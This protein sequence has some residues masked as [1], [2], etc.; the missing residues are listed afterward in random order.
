MQGK[1]L[2]IPGYKSFFKNRIDNS[3]GGLI[4]AVDQNLSSV[5]V[6]SCEEDI[7]VVEIDL[8]NRKIRVINIYGPQEPQTASERQKVLEFWQE[9]EKQVIKSKDDNCLTIL[10]G[11]A[12][13]KLGHLIFPKDPHNQTENGSIMYDFVQRNNLYILNTDNNC[14]GSI[15]RHKITRVKEEKS[16]IDYFVICEGLKQYFEKMFIDDAR[17]YTLTKYSTTKGVKTKTLSDHN[18]LFASFGL[19]YSAVRMKTKYEI[20]DFKNTEGQKKF[21]EVTNTSNKLSKC[22]ESNDDFLHQTDNFLKKLNGTFHQCFAKIRIKNKTIIERKDDIQMSLQKKTDL[23]HLKSQMNSNFTKEFFETKIE[24]IDE[25]ISTKSADRNAHIIREQLDTLIDTEGKFSNVGMWKIKSKLF[26]QVADPPI[27]KKDSEGNL[28]TGVEPLKHL[29]SDT[30]KQRLRHRPMRDDLQDLFS[31]KNLLWELRSQQCRVNVSEAWNMKDLETV[32]KSL[33]NNQSRDPLGMVN[34]IFKPGVVGKDLKTAILALMNG[35]KKNFQIPTFMQ[36]S[37]IT[38]IYKMKGSRLEMENERG[39]FILTVFR[40]IYDKLLYNDKYEYIDSNMSDS[41]I[42]GRK[43]RNIKNHLFIVYGVINAAIGEKTCIDICI[44]DLEKA[45]DSLWIE[46]C[47][48]DLYDTLPR[49]EHD[50]KLAMIFEANRNNLVAIKTPVGLT[51]RTNLPKIVT[52]GGT[53]GPIE[54]ANSIDKIGKKCYDTGENL[55]IYKK[56]VRILPL[57]YID[58]LMTISQCGAQSLKMNTFVGAQ[59]ESKKLKFHTPDASGKSKCNFLHVGKRN[60]ECPDLKVHG[61]NIK[62]VSHETY[63]GDIL[64]D[65]GKNTKNVKNR[66][67][68]GLGIISR[69]MRILEGV[70]LGEH[71]FETAILLR[72]TIFVN[73]I[74]TNVEV[75]YGLKKSEIE[76]FEALDK[77]L[78]RKILKAPSSTPIESL[79]L[80]LGCLDLDTI[81]KS[82]RLNYLHYVITRK[83]SEMLSLFFNTQW[84]YP[85]N[86]KDWVEQVKIDLD[87]FDIPVDLDFIRKKSHLSFKDLVKRKAKERMLQKMLEKKSTHSKMKDLYYTEIQMQKYMKQKCFNVQEAQLIFSFRSRTAKFHGNY[88][89]RNDVQ[90]CPL[91]NLHLDK[92]E[93]V[94]ECPKVKS[95]VKGNLRQIF[96]SEIPKDLVKS[97][98]KIMKQRE[99][100]SKQEEDCLV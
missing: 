69:I 56:I 14:I 44:Y 39:I 4:T 11:D 85:T 64:S 40:K 45:F 5:Q 16:I 34:E 83:E 71:Y 1:S 52:Q 67:S 79:Y 30:Y 88:K 46:D 13:A 42:G 31:L 68:K 76:E 93:L 47:L 98:F 24:E 12:N 53:F 94:L 23:Q 99:N 51:E 43:Q 65:D 70:T 55:F 100:L 60:K 21:L 27:A 72:E 20:F 26:P 81:I 38:T 63:L 22:F 97:L 57:S 96:A 49:D 66:I 54:C 89:G 59:I 91:C 73:G 48:N 32:L 58:D 92:Q 6:S 61:A 80:E 82:R 86:K 29:F 35:M 62:R 74:L 25:I 87:D 2:T 75:W 37:N 90:M 3:G 10:Q 33:K 18:I 36:L 15:T 7:L 19:R 77:M 84:K 17:T 41:N 95:E 9:V 78:L 8:A 28:I 50:D